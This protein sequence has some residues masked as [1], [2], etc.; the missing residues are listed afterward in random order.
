MK[1]RNWPDLDLRARIARSRQ[2]EEMRRDLGARLGDL[3][4]F[5]KNVLHES[6]QRSEDEFIEH[7]KTCPDCRKNIAQAARTGV[8]LSPRILSAAGIEILN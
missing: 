2:I 6:A 1:R 5:M 7:L 3:G 4:E 8:R